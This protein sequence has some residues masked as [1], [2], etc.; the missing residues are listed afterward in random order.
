[1]TARKKTGRGGARPGSGPKPRPA[2]EVRSKAVMLMLTPREHAALQKAAG[3][4]AM[5]TY[6]HRVLARHLKIG[7]KR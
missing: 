1:M 4:E 7:A 3:D 6:A 5:A 2:S